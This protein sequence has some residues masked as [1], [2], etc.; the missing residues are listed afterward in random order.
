RHLGFKE[1]VPQAF[2]AGLLHDMGKL[3]ILSVLEH[4]LT[5][6]IIR[7]VN[8]LCNSMEQNGTGSDPTAILVMPEARTLNLTEPEIHELEMAIQSDIALR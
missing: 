2:I 6:S 1:L 7:L 5:V 3:H 4:I 8:A